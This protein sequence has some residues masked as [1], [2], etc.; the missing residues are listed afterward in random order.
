[1]ARPAFPSY[2]DVAGPGGWI[3]AMKAYIDWFLT[4]DQSIIGGTAYIFQLVD[5][6]YPMDFT[7]ATLVTITI[8]ANATVNFPVN[9]MIEGC[10]AGAGQLQ[11]VAAAGVTLRMP[12]GKTGKTTGQWSSFVLRQRVT[13]EWVLGGDIV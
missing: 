2:K 9:A 7:G 10:Q 6:G 12:A 11:V 13:N 1:M 4:P 3:A 8:P 5:V